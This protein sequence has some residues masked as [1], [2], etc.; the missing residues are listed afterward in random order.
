MEAL[1]YDMVRNSETQNLIEKVSK[2]SSEKIH[3]RTRVVRTG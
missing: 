2:R 1:D 3:V